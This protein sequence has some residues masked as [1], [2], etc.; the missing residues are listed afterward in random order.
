MSAEYVVT[1]TSIDYKARIDGFPDAARQPDSP[2]F[3]PFGRSRDIV[4]SWIDT[5][6]PPARPRSIYLIVNLTDH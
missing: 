6:A 3:E 1:Y 2:E 4:Y 5:I